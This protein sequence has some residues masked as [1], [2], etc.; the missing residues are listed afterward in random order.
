MFA[1]RILGGDLAIPKREQVATGDFD[2]P[3]I[4]PCAGEGPLGHTAV[5]RHE[6]PS[7]APVCIRILGEHGLIRRTDGALSFVPLAVDVIARGRL[8]YAV[9]RHH[10]HQGLDVMTIPR[11]S[12]RLEQSLQ[13]SICG[14]SA[15]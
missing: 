1:K 10:R 12:E 3:A 15:G 8:E 7:V 6:V 9:F 14:R 2:P 13:M 5:P 4:A 11:I